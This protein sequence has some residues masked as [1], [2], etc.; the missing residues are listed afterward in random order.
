M[1]K[2]YAVQ[3]GKQ[4]GTSKLL[5]LLIN[6]YWTKNDTFRHKALTTGNKDVYRI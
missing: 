4:Q 1:Y 6:R 2:V 5:D 3:R